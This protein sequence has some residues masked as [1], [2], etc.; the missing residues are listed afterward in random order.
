VLHTGNTAQ[1]QGQ[2][3]LQT[4]RLENSFQANGLK[5]QTGLAFLLSNKIGF[6]PKVSKEM[7]KNIPTHQKKNPP[8]GTLNSEYL[9][10]ECKGTHICKRNVTEAQNTYCT[11]HNYSGRFQH[12]TITNG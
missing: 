12:P 11:S 5:K 9:Y 4:K 3:L 10:P 7:E 6:Q 2:T 8:R 1:L